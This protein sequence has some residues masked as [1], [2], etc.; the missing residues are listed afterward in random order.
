M[1][2]AGK[3]KS[4][5]GSHGGLKVSDD[6][7]SPRFRRRKMQRMLENNPAL[8]EELT[9]QMILNGSLPEG[10]INSLKAED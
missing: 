9:K 4:G 7:R 10:Y 6:K 8:L 2:K 1:A 5:H 3:S